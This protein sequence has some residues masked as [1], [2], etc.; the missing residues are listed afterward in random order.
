MSG[1]GLAG[2]CFKVVCCS[3]L[4]YVINSFRGLNDCFFRVCKI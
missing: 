3:K 4:K 2:S 1:R